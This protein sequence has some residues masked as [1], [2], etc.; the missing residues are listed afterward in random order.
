MFWPHVYKFNFFLSFPSKHL[1]LDHLL[2]SIY[3]T[4]FTICRSCQCNVQSPSVYQMYCTVTMKGT[5]YILDYNVCFLFY[6]SMTTVYPNITSRWEKA[7]LEEQGRLKLV[8]YFNTEDDI[9]PPKAPQHLYNRD[10]TRKKEKNAPSTAFLLPNTRLIH[11]FSHS[12][13]CPAATLR[14]VTET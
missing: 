2:C 5:D 11:R 9:S 12:S 8:I 13:D 4:P 14:A 7:L 6:L 3:H 10:C 1:M